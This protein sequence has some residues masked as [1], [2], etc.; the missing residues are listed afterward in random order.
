[1]KLANDSFS[2]KSKGYRNMA[3]IQTAYV[4][5]TF[6]C[7]AL[8]GCASHYSVCPQGQANCKAAQAVEKGEVFFEQGEWEKAALAF[9]EVPSR[10]GVES[11]FRLLKQRA[12]DKALALLFVAAD[13]ALLEDRV[14]DADQLFKR[15]LALDKVN[16][17]IESGMQSVERARNHQRF[18]NKAKEA[19][20]RKDT[21]AAY[22]AIERVLLE[23]PRNEAALA[24]Q[25]QLDETTRSSSDRALAAAYRKPISI[26]FKDATIKSV[27][28][29]LALTSGIN[30]VLDKDVPGDKRTSVYLRRSTVEA[31][32]NVVM[33]SNQLDFRVLD[34][35]TILVYPDT[36]EKQKIFQPLSVKSFFL[37][38]AEAKNIAASLKTMLQ[39]EN[40]VVD[41]KLNMV[42]V[43][44]HPD[45]LRQVEKVIA[46]HDRAEPEVMLEVEILEVTRT[47]LSR[48]G[49]TWPDTLTLSPLVS[50]A[51]RGLT[52]S[53]LND[54]RPS[55][56][57]AALGATTLNASQNVSAVNILANPRIRVKNKG[58]ADILIGDRVPNI[59]ST[60][61][62]TGFLS[63]SISYIDVGLK[64]K[65][66]PTVFLDGTIEIVTSL[67][68]SNIANTVT[69]R[70]GTVAYQIG[71]RSANTVLRL[72]DNENQ[73]LAGLINDQDRQGGAGIPGFSQLPLVGRLFGT[74]TGDHSKTEIV[75]SITPRLLRTVSRPDARGAEFDTGTGSNP[76]VRWPIGTNTGAAEPS[77]DKTKNATPPATPLIRTSNPSDLAVKTI[78]G[79]SGVKASDLN[80]SLNQNEP[81]V[82]KFFLVGNKQV[83]VGDNFVVQLVANQAEKITNLPV[84]LHFDSKRVKVLSVTE[85][86][87][88]KSISPTKMV[89]N[90]DEKSGQ[91]SISLIRI[92]QQGKES[93]GP[94]VF[95]KPSTNG[96]VLLEFLVTAIKGSGQTALTIEANNVLGEDGKSLIL[97]PPTA[98]T[99]LVVP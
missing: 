7:F 89:S 46:L 17:R 28:E 94:I 99:V 53:D 72:K 69:T 50:G 43:R 65:V 26:E 14:D 21:D 44:A 87:A 16:P 24:L 6:L 92:L 51:G 90:I 32:L 27:M 78:G 48:L 11:E 86:A 60:A 98:H 62:A 88:M 38:N 64:L 4:V 75:L 36:P 71:T 83:K 1:M 47:E 96:Q 73:V 29:V 39:L 74:K 93:N 33:L 9:A 41:E 55:T 82:A 15:A 68:I 34:S 25:R 13:R 10:P 8:A 85:G 67:E 30:F 5:L 2:L 23:A 35:N 63:E 70:A 40:T 58:K 52:L 80:N 97:L 22:A 61:T 77:V 19:L 45:V 57:G 91:A 20:V 95:N 3:L 66:E 84:T 18:I 12:T 54:L 59:T 79:D 56:I 42:M 31:A 49:V 76:R 81:E 37:F